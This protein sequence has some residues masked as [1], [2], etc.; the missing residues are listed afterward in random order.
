M[1][2]KSWWRS[3]NE[4]DDDQKAFIQLSPHGRYSLEGPP[5]SG[6]TNL[7]LLRAQFVAGTG[8]KNVLIVTY[9]KA[10]AD[11]IR[12]GIHA[13]GLIS[14]NQVKTYHAWAYSHILEHLGQRA[15]PEDADFGDAARQT[16]LG[17]LKE[18]NEKLPTRKLFSAI[19]V[20]EAQDLTADELD[21]L[22][23]LS[24]NISI[25][26]DARQSI[27]NRNGLS[28][29]QKLNLNQHVLKRHFRIGQKIAKVA[30]KLM[31]P[32]N[33]AESLE[34]TSNY[35]SKVQ[36]ESSAYMNPCASRDEQFEKMVQA[37]EI[38]LDAFKGD[39]IGIFCATRNTLTELRQRFDGTKF[40]EKVCVHGIDKDSSFGGGK[41]IHVLTIHAA[42]GTEF[43]AVHL[44]GAEELVKHRLNHRHLGYTAV[45]RAKTSLNVYRTGDTN[46]PLENAFAQPKHMELD[47]LFPG[48]KS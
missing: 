30:D 47:D 26:G 46:Q 6:K 25:C 1:M 39:S 34:A 3:K 37:I 17:M 23:S 44:F 4:L 18:A 13:M 5:G 21:V 43:R 20:D 40:K 8:E 27:Y 12:T 22:L 9:T 31:P 10:L 28:A 35:D 33:I 45:T 7:L 16:I 19:F 24:D 15:L 29:V 48:D 2:E 42:K 36:G 38:Q 41:L 11:F 14:P 32:S